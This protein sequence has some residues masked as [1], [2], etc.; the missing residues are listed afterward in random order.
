MTSIPLNA[1]LAAET[2]ANPPKSVEVIR[3]Q[4]APLNYVVSKVSLDFKLY[5]GRTIVE[6]VLTVT[7]N[8]DLQNGESDGGEDGLVLDGEEATVK[9]LELSVDGCEEALVADVDYVLK[10]GKLIIKGD[11]LRRSKMIVRTTVEIVPED[12]TQLSGLYKSGDMYCTQCEAEGFRRIT[13][14]P[15]RPDVMATFEQVRVEANAKDFPV[16]LSNG[17]LVKEGMCDGGTNGDKRKFA[18]WSDP[19]PKPSYLFALVAGDLGCLEDSFTTMSGRNVALRFYSEHKN[20]S[21]LSYAVES[22]KRAMKWDEG[23][24]T[25]LDYFVSCHLF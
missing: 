16:L 20:V 2:K 1:A 15:D 8:N 18:V 5:T 13:Y 12:N 4:Y 19:F 17:N 7:A 11:T 10:P 25:F 9:L 21:K 14:Y 24:L 23:E 22:L 6:S 3:L